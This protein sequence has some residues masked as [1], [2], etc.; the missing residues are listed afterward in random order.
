MTGWRWKNVICRSPTAS[1]F[2]QEGL[3]T[4]FLANGAGARTGGPPAQ[5]NV[6]P[7]SAARFQ[8]LGIF[9]INAGECVRFSPPFWAIGNIEI[10]W[11]TQK[12][13]KWRAFLRICLRSLHTSDW[14]AGAGGFRTSVWRNQNPLPYHLATPQCAIGWPPAAAQGARPPGRRT[15]ATQTPSINACREAA[16]K[17]FRGYRRAYSRREQHRARPQRCALYH[18]A[19]GCAL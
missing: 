14:L 15:I 9:Q 10:Y 19:K 18:P 6:E 5:S 1:S 2:A 4:L 17:L 16:A 8:N 3:K 12:A 11:S 7:F 13:P